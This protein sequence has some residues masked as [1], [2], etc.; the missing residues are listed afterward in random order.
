MKKISVNMYDSRFPN[1][2]SEFFD[3]LENKEEYLDEYSTY[4]KMFLAYIIKNSSIKRIENDIKECK[5]FKYPIEGAYPD[6][7]DLYQYLCN[8]DLKYFYVRSNIYIERLSKEEK[9][10]LDSIVS[11]KDFRYDDKAEKFIKDT[12]RKLIT[13]EL[14]SKEDKSYYLNF[15]PSESRD[16]F[17][18]NDSLV[19]GARMYPG[20]PTKDMNE[21]RDLYFP[22]LGY[23]S[24]KCSELE[25]LL[26]KELEIE[27][28]VI[29]YDDNTVRKIVIDKDKTL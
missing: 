11:S 5:D 17:A 3:G 23:F 6:D 8:E 13:E 29:E 22:R 1:G 19:I 25:E 21:L 4:V 24:E 10:Y 2:N 15:G 7:Q 18:L 26:K 9:E 14:D 16:F 28:K 12:F 27:T 20:I